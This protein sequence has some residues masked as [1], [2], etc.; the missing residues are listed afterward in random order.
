MTPDPFGDYPLPPLPYR[1]TP[2]PPGDEPRPLTLQAF[3]RRDRLGR[4][5]WYFRIRGANG[6]P[7]AASEAYNS[8]ASRDAAVRLL[9][10]TPILPLWIENRPAI[11]HV[12]NP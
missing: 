2:R 11:G 1:Y 10:T 6:E 5:R 9:T 8:A 4:R 12:V 3:E 7:I